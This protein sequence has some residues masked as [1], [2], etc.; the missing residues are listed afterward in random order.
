MKTLSPLTPR[1]GATLLTLFTVLTA[2]VLLGGC[3]AAPRAWDPVRPAAESSSVVRTRGDAAPVEWDRLDATALDEPVL[4]TA[5]GPVAV[6]FFG[7]TVWMDAGTTAF[8]GASPDTLYV[9]CLDGRVADATALGVTGETRPAV[10]ASA[11]RLL[12]WTPADPAPRSHAFDA[13][14]LRGSV[15]LVDAPNAEAALADLERQQERRIWW[16]RLQ[17]TGVNAV[18]STPAAQ[19]A[20]RAAYLQNADVVGLRFNPADPDTLAQ[21]VANAFVAALR[22][23]DG[24]RAARLMSPRLGVEGAEDAATDNTSRRTLAHALAGRG[25]GALAEPTPVDDDPLTFHVAGSGDEPEA[26]YRLDLAEGDGLYYVTA[27]NRQT[28]RQPATKAAGR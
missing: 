14:Y 27:F 1:C 28:A 11:G 7:R 9:A 26:D 5:D 25:W 18:A 20:Q 4:V 23:G 6:P 19:N 21:R 24:D 16:G 12:L 10:E 22:D 15:D 17:P 13:T 3:H 8:F 2:A